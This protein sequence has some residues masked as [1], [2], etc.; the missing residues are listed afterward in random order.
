MKMFLLREI[1]TTCLSC[2]MHALAIVRAETEEAA[3]NILH[4]SNSH[5]QWLRGT[6]WLKSD[7]VSCVELPLLD[8]PR[9]IVVGSWLEQHFPG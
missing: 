5:G 2:D 6:Q 4:N 1:V 8:G 9:G 7:F 3:R